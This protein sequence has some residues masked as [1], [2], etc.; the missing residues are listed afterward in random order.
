VHDLIEEG[1]RKLGSP[2]GGLELSCGVYPPTPP[3]N[4]D[5]LIGAMEEYRTCWFDGRAAG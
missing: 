5:A 4:V 2:E 1:V 3:E